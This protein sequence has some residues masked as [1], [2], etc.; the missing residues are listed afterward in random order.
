MMALGIS[1]SG[2]FHPLTFVL[3]T[4]TTKGITS[5]THTSTA[6]TIERV[7]AGTHVISVEVLEPFVGIPVKSILFLMS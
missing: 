7:V 2:L 1:R 4:T 5:R 6:R 3:P